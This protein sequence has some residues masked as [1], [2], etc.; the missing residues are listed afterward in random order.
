MARGVIEDPEPADPRDGLS[1]HQGTR[2]RDGAVDP[3]PGDFLGP[4]NAGEAN[5][6]GPSVVNPGLHGTGERPVVPGPVRK[7]GVQHHRESNAS[8]SRRVKA[9]PEPDDEQDEAE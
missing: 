2:L 5:P 4:S 6:H 1:H 3:A 8:E 7:P 9:L